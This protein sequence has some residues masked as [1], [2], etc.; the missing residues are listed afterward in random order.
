MSVE[1]KLG[2]VVGELK[3]I[4]ADIQE[5]KDGQDTLVQRIDHLEGWKLRT[6][7]FA[8]GIAA[9]VS[10]FFTYILKG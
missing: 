2:E 7:G 10:L 5:L 3:G 4:R 1:M 6:A 9:A 8:S